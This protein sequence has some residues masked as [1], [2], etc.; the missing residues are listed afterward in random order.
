MNIPSRLL[1]VMNSIPP[2]D[3]RFLDPYSDKQLLEELGIV[4]QDPVFADVVATRIAEIVGISKSEY[5][6]RKQ[7]ARQECWATNQAGRLIVK[8]PRKKGQAYT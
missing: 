5:Y 6:T 7:R 4:G 1:D 2:S 8:S 3:V